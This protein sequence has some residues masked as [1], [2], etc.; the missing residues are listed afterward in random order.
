MDNP[1]T[2]TTLGKQDTGQRPTKQI[3]QHRKL[4]RWATIQHLFNTYI[5]QWVNNQGLSKVKSK[6]IQHYKNKS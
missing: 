1:E 6:S 3:T 2:L 5:V 4:K